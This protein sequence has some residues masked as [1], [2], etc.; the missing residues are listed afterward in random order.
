MGSLR[1]V[2]EIRPIIRELGAER[3]R[4]SSAEKK[5]RIETIRQGRPT[6]DIKIAVVASAVLLKSIADAGVPLKLFYNAEKAW[7]A[8]GI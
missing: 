5:R 7:K 2:G 1:L 3:R 4:F 8:H 6:L